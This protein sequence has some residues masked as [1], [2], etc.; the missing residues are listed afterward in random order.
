MLKDRSRRSTA[1]T[2]LIPIFIFALL[3]SSILFAQNDK[4]ALEQILNRMD[5]TAAT[6]HAAKA[7]FDWD[8]FTAVVNEHDRKVGT[9]Y[10]RKQG[11]SVEMMAEV[12]KPDSKSAEEYVLYKSGKV[13]I[14]YPGTGQVQEHP[15]GKN[16][17]DVQ[18]FLLL[19][20][21]GAGHDL[22]KSFDVHYAGTE[23]IG[24]VD[25]AKLELTPKS[26]SV[27]GMFNKIILW[28]DPRTGLSVRQELMSASGDYKLS[29]YSD[30]EVNPK[31]PP[32][33]FKLKK[34]E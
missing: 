17:A 30:I 20:F 28:I 32:D 6:F 18:T 25:A 22:A 12:R 11:K 4:A 33:V 2:C 3:F 19:G 16:K 5:Q 26:E 8:T 27:K 29:K 7:D 14:Y 15:V 34:A 21:G 13:Q 1:L 9:V 10:Y 24:T 31:L 23:K